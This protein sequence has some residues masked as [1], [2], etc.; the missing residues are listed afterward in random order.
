M[1]ANRFSTRPLYLQI[2]DALVERISSGEWKPGATLPNEA[3]LARAFGVSL[4]TI[5]KA[6]DFMETERLLTR[7]QGSGTFVNDQASD[8]LV[9]RFDN[10]RAANGEHIDAD[11]KT[12]AMSEG[13]ANE[14]ECARLSLQPSHRAYRIRRVHL[15]NG[16]PFLVE[17]TAMPAE[18]FPGLTE[19]THVPH[20]IVVLAQQ[21][22]IL[23][24]KAAERISIGTAEASITTAL[25][26]AE[27]SPVL[28]MDRVVVALGGRP[29]EWRVGYCHFTAGGYYLATME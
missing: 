17:E 8:E 11:V 19:K 26:L 12:A 1:I 16:R 24:G 10:I 28:V 2:R 27:G 22:G 15:H 6:L 20:R 4:G 14:L 18:L 25:N 21:Y 5:R 7:R 9:T 23:L 3:D 29:I 13:M